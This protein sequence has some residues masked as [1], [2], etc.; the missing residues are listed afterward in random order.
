MTTLLAKG[1]CILSLI[2]NQVSNA[3]SVELVKFLDE[4]DAAVE[5]ENI[6][7]LMNL[8][9][10]VAIPSDAFPGH[11]VSVLRVEHEE[12][13]TRVLSLYKSVCLAD[14]QQYAPEVYALLITKDVFARPF[15]VRSE[16]NDEHNEVALDFKDVLASLAEATFREEIYW[17]VW[18]Y[19]QPSPFRARYLATVAPDITLSLLLDG[20]EVSLTKGLFHPESGPI[21]FRFEPYRWFSINEMLEILHEMARLDLMKDASQLDR[22]VKVLQEY[23]RF[24]ATGEEYMRRGGSYVPWRDYLSRMMAIEILEQIATSRHREA[25]ES[26][27]VGAPVLEAGFP[28]RV[29]S[30]FSAG[31][32]DISARVAILLERLSNEE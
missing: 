24:F 10:E 18:A 26:L 5:E 30:M 20:A 1:I 7:A 11:R 16:S 32:Q 17:F 21:L 13:Q 29:R 6:S 3:S 8:M 12:L 25:V 14:T 19:A 22:T 9:E 2:A 28:A 4:W 15:T 31:E 23:G 27:G